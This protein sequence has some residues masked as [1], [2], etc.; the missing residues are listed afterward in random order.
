MVYCLN[1]WNSCKPPSRVSDR[2]HFW[3]LNTSFVFNLPY[4]M[5]TIGRALWLAVERA[6][7]SCNDRALWRLLWVVSKSHECLR[8][9]DKKYGQSTTIYE[10]S[11]S[12]SE[13]NDFLCAQ[14][15]MENYFR[16]FYRIFL[17]EKGYLVNNLLTSSVGSL[18]G[19][20]RPRPWWPR[21]RSEIFV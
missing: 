13:S 7:F 21:P 10:E 15:D 2:D 17:G 12:E 1:I 6:R 3:S 16:C 20:L 5:A 14:A 19:N 8:E 9:N 11:H 4:C 18:Q